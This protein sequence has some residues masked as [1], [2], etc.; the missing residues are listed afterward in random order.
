MTKVTSRTARR[1]A[2]RERLYEAAVAEFRRTGVSGADVGSIV[3]EAAVAHGTF[4]FHFPSKEHVVAELGRREERR[5]AAELDRFLNARHELEATLVEV[6]RMTVALER[7][8]GPLLFKDM[9]ALYFS[10]NRKELQP[11]SDHPVITRV[12]QEFD[13]AQRDGRFRKDVE[14]S[15]VAMI[16]L[17]GLYALLLTQDRN[18]ERTRVL[19][20][21]VST[22]LRGLSSGV[23]SIT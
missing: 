8:L 17:L 13:V 18:A 22:V 4:F 14:S 7:R 23:R 10:P 1:V 2:T 9:L 5:M 6:V 11:W 16:F 3:A 15:D 21:Y 19:E 20:E 12:I